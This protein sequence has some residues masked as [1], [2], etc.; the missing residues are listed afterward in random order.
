MIV[1]MIFSCLFGLL[2]V[3]VFMFF[4]IYVILCEIEDLHYVNINIIT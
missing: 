2:G 3:F 1:F 4:C